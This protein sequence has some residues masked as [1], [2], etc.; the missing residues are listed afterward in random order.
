[1]NFMEKDRVWLTPAQLFENIKDKVQKYKPKSPVLNPKE[2]IE[3]YVKNR[4]YLTE[5]EIFFSIALYLKNELFNYPD[6]R[7]WMKEKYSK[8]A[9]ITTTPTKKGE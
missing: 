7:R 4:P 9:V 2:E 1:M 6:L 5:T 3:S 8:R